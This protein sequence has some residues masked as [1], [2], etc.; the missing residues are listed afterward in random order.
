MEAH[1]GTAEVVLWIVWEPSGEFEVRWA[2]DMDSTL[3]EHDAVEVNGVGN[4]EPGAVGA[5]ARS[6]VRSV[7]VHMGRGRFA[8][9][10][11]VLGQA[12]PLST[13]PCP[14]KRAGVAPERI[15]LEGR[16]LY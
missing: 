11:A 10:A 2:R 8:R 5:R 1:E 3:G 4:I 15:V 13:M 12:D 16:Y 7:P 14:R 6:S 9:A